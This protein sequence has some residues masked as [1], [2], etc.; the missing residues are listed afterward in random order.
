MDTSII[1]DALEILVFAVM[2]LISIS[3]ALFVV[4]AKDIVR[5]AL[6]LI[7][8]MFVVAGLYIM[9]NAQ[10]LGVIQVLVYVGAIGVLIMFAV[11]LT[12]KE[13]GSDKDDE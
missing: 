10:F 5:S 6:S 8:V 3:C 2:A 12:K 9:L 4:T 1:A 13:F 11:M 7:V